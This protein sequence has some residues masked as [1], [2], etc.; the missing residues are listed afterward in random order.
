MRRRV[1]GNIPGPPLLR[2]DDVASFEERHGTDRPRLAPALRHDRVEPFDPGSRL[3]VVAS[4]QVAVLTPIE[5]VHRVAHGIA[6]LPEVAGRFV[7]GLV[8]AGYQVPH[9]VLD[10]DMRGHVAGV[11]HRRRNPGKNVRRRQG[12]R[13]VQR[14]IEGVDYIVRGAGMVGVPVE[15]AKGNRPGPH[16]ESEA[17]VSEGP[18]AA[19]HGQRMEGG[20]LVVHRVLLVQ[21]GHRLHVGDPALAP[22]TF[23][24]QVFDGF[25]KAL[26]AG[27]GRLGPT[28]FRSGA[29]ALQHCARRVGVGLGLQ[30]MIVGERLA[31]VGQRK[32]RI[33]GLRSLE[34]PDRL[35]PSEAVKNGY[36]AQEVLLRLARGRSRK[37]DRADVLELR[38]RRRADREHNPRNREYGRNSLD[39]CHRFFSSEAAT[40]A[41]GNQRMVMS[42]DPLLQRRGCAASAAAYSLP[43]GMAWSSGSLYTPF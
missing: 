33:D 25:E 31:P 40:R 10:E 9:A 34:L 24:P 4:L 15:Y 21:T 18:R 42:V 36:A 2:F 30:R 20:D 19:Q 37:V 35:L 11:G 41:A 23:S 12:D 3:G 6:R 32:V 16:L 8:A 28:F 22:S 39:G 17:V 7:R 5:R 27:G 14:I 26:F 43:H 1:A 29:Q 38:L 13:G